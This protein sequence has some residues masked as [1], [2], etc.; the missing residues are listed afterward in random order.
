[1]SGADKKKK[2][3]GYIVEF[4]NVDAILDAARRVRD[5]GYKRWDCHT[6]FP[7]HGLDGAMG[8]RMTIL[9]LIVFAA[10]VIGLSAGLFMQWWMNAFDYTYQIS[11]KP[12]W[13]IPANIPVA[14]EMTV[15]FA[16]F[17]AFFGMLGLNRLPEYYHSLF[18]ATRFQ[19]ATSDRF[20]LAIEAADPRFD[21]TKTWSFLESLGSG[22][23]EEVEE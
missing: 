13:S 4:D 11:G 17:G 16:A 3:Y 7:V 21:E 12:F 1:M 20:I 23:I 10:G 19:R 8:I 6:P 5:E 2:L 18:K 9:P 14:F 15:L 22:T